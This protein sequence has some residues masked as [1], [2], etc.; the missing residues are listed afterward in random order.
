MN[1]GVP[2]WFATSPISLKNLAWFRVLLQMQPC[3][4]SKTTTNRYHIPQ[5]IALW[6]QLLWRFPSFYVDPLLLLPSLSEPGINKTSCDLVTAF[7]NSP[8]VGSDRPF[9]SGA[10][11]WAY[12]TYLIIYQKFPRCFT[13]DNL[14]WELSYIVDLQWLNA[15]C[16]DY[17]QMF[18]LSEYDCYG[19]KIA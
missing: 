18:N 4:K 13:S 6:D 2:N 3:W 8:L 11:M 5:L 9:S 19:R 10:Q 17:C 7:S 12:L 16:K 14:L 15:L 1:G